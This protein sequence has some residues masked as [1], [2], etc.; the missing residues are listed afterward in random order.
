MFSFKKKAII[1]KELAEK[2]QEIQAVRHDTLKK[3]GKATS[4]NERLKKLLEANG[5][6][7]NILVATGGDRRGK[8]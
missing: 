3:I 5:I 8:H 6:T 1:K 2:E 7:L 4:T